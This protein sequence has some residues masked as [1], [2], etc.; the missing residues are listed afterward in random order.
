MCNFLDGVSWVM[1]PEQGWALAV[2]L[3]FSSEHLAWRLFLEPQSPSCYLRDSLEWVE[4]ISLSRSEFLN[5]SVSLSLT[6]TFLEVK[7]RPNFQDVTARVTQAKNEQK[8][9]FYEHEL[10]LRVS[11]LAYTWDFRDQNLYATP[12]PLPWA[13]VFCNALHWCVGRAQAHGWT[14]PAG[15]MRLCQFCGTGSKASRVQL[16][17]YNMSCWPCMISDF[18]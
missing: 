9:D 6:H 8:L 5:L 2:V 11:H 14:L 17:M 10:D 4:E 1:A 7:Q 12:P 15:W 3:L 18:F 13:L 16:L